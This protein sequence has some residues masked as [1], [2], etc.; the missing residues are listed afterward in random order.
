MLEATTSVKGLS[1]KESLK[2][3]ISYVQ[4]LKRLALKLVYNSFV[5]IPSKV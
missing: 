3:W 5:N 2:V 4:N 1:K